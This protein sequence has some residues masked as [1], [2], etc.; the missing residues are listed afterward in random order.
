MGKLNSGGSAKP[1]WVEVRGWRTK[2][3]EQCQDTH[4][5]ARASRRQCGTISSAVSKRLQSGR[6]TCAQDA[7][8]SGGQKMCVQAQFGNLFSPG[9]WQVVERHINRSRPS[10]MTSS[11]RPPLAGTGPIPTGPFEPKM[12]RVAG[13]SDLP[14]WIDA[15]G[16]LTCASCVSSLAVASQLRLCCAKASF[17]L[18]NAIPTS[19]PPAQWR[20]GYAT[21][22]AFASRPTIWQQ[23][24]LG[25]AHAILY[26]LV[27]H[28]MRHPAPCG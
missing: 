8:P 16:H 15:P 5:P 7:L 23:L 3:Q 13:P 4:L 18:H 22:L 26:R 12:L 6:V 24:Y 10:T 17:A 2:I 14:A 20:P 21:R 1:V 11:K 25:C 28:Q 27:I 9:G 19:N